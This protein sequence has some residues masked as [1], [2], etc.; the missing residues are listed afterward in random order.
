MKPEDLLNYLPALPV[1]LIWLV[2]G[3]VALVRWHRHPR[4]SLIMLIATA[5][6]IAGMLLNA[7]ASWWVVK[8]IN[9]GGWGITE[10]RFALL[11]VSGVHS[12]LNAAAYTLLLIAVF[13]WRGGRRAD[14]EAE[15]DFPHDA[16]RP[17]GA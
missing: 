5:L 15:E 10:F 12:L 6:F 4:V 17:P 11:A 9:A 2:G 16:P 14:A 8:Q 1:Y 7:V 3:I 13:G